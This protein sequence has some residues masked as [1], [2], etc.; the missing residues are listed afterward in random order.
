MRDPLENF[1]DPTTILDGTDTLLSMLPLLSLVLLAPICSFTCCVAGCLRGENRS[2]LDRCTCT[3][4]DDEPGVISTGC[5]MGDNDPG[6]DSPLG[7]RLKAADSFS[8]TSKQLLK[9]TKS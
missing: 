9:G 8:Q 2:E 3:L 5:L 4:G 1:C 7:L 6:V